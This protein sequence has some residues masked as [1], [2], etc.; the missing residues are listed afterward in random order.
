MSLAATSGSLI[1]GLSDQVLSVQF[2][3]PEL[4]LAS[5][6]GSLSVHFNHR[7]VPP[8]LECWALVSGHPNAGQRHATITP[9]WK[10]DAL[11]LDTQGVV[12]LDVIGK[13]TPRKPGRQSIHCR[14]FVERQQK[15]GRVVGSTHE[16][17]SSSTNSHRQCDKWWL[18]SPRVGASLDVAVGGHIRV[19]LRRGVGGALEEDMLMKSRTFLRTRRMSR[20][21]T[22]SRFYEPVFRETRSGREETRR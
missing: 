6:V 10:L 13:K 1:V 5:L 20:R 7:Q 12:S 2:D 16:E 18:D 14:G 9:K 22:P 11:K 15:G 17:P 8:L 19:D 4:S 3:L 21:T